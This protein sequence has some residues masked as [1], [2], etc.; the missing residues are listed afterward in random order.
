MRII[1]SASNAIDSDLETFS[2]IWPTRESQDSLLGNAK[3]TLMLWGSGSLLTR[4]LYL[5]QDLP[6]VVST[7]SAYPPGGTYISDLTIEP[8]SSL[9]IDRLVVYG[10]LTAPGT[11]ANPIRISAGSQGTTGLIL[12]DTATSTLSNVIFTGRT[13][14]ANQQHQVTLQG[15]NSTGFI[16]LGSPGSRITDSKIHSVPAGALGIG[17]G[18]I[19][20]RASGVQVLRC[21]VTDNGGD[22]IHVT[23]E[24]SEGVEIHDCNLARNGGFGVNNLAAFTVDARRNWWGDPAGPSG[25]SGDG[26]SGNVDTSDPLPAPRP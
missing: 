16:E 11:V 22:G 4:P 3:D 12:S 7:H 13:I 25:S 23:S 26:V 17:L 1:G 5:R 19:F 14:T 20:V 15:I 8:G 18:A 10:N 21:D 2:Q 9:Q 24:V 6:W